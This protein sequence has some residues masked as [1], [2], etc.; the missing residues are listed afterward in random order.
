MKKLIK[1]DKLADHKKETLKNLNKEFSEEM[2]INFYN[3]FVNILGTIKNKSSI[4]VIEKLPTIKPIYSFQTI[5]DLLREF[6]E[7][8][9]DV[10]GD[11]IELKKY[12]G[13][14]VDIFM[15]INVIK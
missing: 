8:A 5:F 11:F 15:L 9:Y 12:I 6:S 14:D 3:S 10:Q 13:F 2:I 1:Y 7:N 4:E